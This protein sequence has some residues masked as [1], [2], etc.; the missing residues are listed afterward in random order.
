MVVARYPRFGQLLAPATL[1]PVLDVPVPR[2][3][4]RRFAPKELKGVRLADLDVA[5]WERFGPEACRCL[6]KA[7]VRQVH[8]AVL[9][10]L[11]AIRR[12]RLPT[13]EHA[14]SIDDLAL[15]TRTRTCLYR[16]SL[17]ADLRRLGNLT[18]DD[19]LALRG[20]GAK[21][22]VDLLASLEMP[23]VPAL[24][25]AEKKG[26]GPPLRPAPVMLSWVE[27]TRA[28]YRQL[29]SNASEWTF[30]DLPAMLRLE[31]LEINFRTRR[32]LGNSRFGKDLS[33]LSGYPILRLLHLPSF[34]V[35]SLRSFLR[36]LDAVLHPVPQPPA[37]DLET[38]LLH[39]FL[40]D[41]KSQDAKKVRNRHIFMRVYGLDGQ[42]GATLGAIGDA[43]GITKERVRQLCKLRP[44]PGRSVSRLESALQ[45]VAEQLPAPAEAIE[46]ELMRRGLTSRSLPLWSL[47]RFA[48][49]LGYT[50]PFKLVGSNR[51]RWAVHPDAPDKP[52]PG[53]RRR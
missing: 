41:C 3:L 38:E 30:P 8:G 35:L 23:S 47:A 17:D 28:D 7:V 33:A 36:G 16:A 37:P 31:Q 19:V 44:R 42:G 27:W 13:L 18:I 4:V 51:R 40:S 15:E 10:P 46:A 43:E 12:Q 26:T 11:A 9:S 1:R 21:C 5:S 49:A 53:S 24:R 52:I 48:R 32:C 45:V 6:A 20:F 14:R 50:P 22:L 2:H 29:P 25:A 34:G 39:A